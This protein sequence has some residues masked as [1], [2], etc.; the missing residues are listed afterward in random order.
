MA[1]IGSFT[2]TA[3]GYAGTLKTLTLEVKLRFVPE[4]KDKEAAPDY[5]LLAGSTEL[6]VAWRKTARETGR[7]YLSVKLDDPAFP[8]PV[9]AR[10]VEVEG[11]EDGFALI[12]SRRSGD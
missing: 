8:A 7:E 12:W 11:E 10:L 3:S 2:K 6:G 5:R 4:A 9:H 1:T